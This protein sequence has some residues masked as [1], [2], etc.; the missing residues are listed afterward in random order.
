MYHE[1][2]KNT[3]EKAKVHINNGAV[4]NYLSL[5]R[6]DSC[7][8]NVNLKPSICAACRTIYT[9]GINIST[10]CGAVAPPVVPTERFF[11]L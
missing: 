5:K 4:L 2:Y 10:S 3:I 1:T 8:N 7:F 11:A 6:E 9:P